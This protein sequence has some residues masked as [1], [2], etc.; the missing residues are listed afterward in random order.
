MLVTPSAENTSSHHHHLGENR[1]KKGFSSMVI[2]AARSAE[3]IYSQNN[4]ANTQNEM[5]TIS[6]M[7]AAAT[8]IFRKGKIIHIHKMPI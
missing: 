7:G 8:E 1:N 2:K 4:K 5:S 6:P 3:S